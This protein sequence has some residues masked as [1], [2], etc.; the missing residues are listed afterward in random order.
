[1]TKE[2]SLSEYITLDR[3]AASQGKEKGFTKK[4]RIAIL[5]SFTL[6]GFK[7]VLNVK[8]RQSRIKAL[9]YT[10]DY[11]RYANDLLDRESRLYRFKPEITFLF[12]D[13]KSLFGEL[14]FNP[15]GA[16]EREREKASRENYQKLN[17][18]IDSFVKHGSGILVVNNLEIPV[19]SPVGILEPKQRFGY[20]D[21]VRDLNARISRFNRH[22]S[23]F[24][25]DYDSFASA[26]GKKGMVDNKLAY[27]ADMKIAPDKIP[28]LCEEYMRY[29]GPLLGL[30]KKC[31]V[32]DMD[33]TLWGGIVGEDGL[34]GID[35]GPER[36]GNAYMEFQKHLLALFE[37]GIILAAN[38]SN[39]E[40]DV[41]KVLREHPH[42]V[43]KEHHFA[44]F[45]VNWNNKAKNL[46]EIAK[47][48]NIG[49]DSMIFLEDDKRIRAFIRAALPQ[50]YCPDIPED[51]S[52]YTEFL[53]SIK[54]LDSLQLTG[55]DKKR[56]IGYI[57]ERKR[58]ESKAV[59]KSVSGYL[60]HLSITVRI[61][62]AD[63]FSVPRIA[64]LTTR[65]N[66]FN[67]SA[68]RYRENEI[69]RF[70]R[71]KRY[72]VYSVSIKDKYGDY[73]ITGALIVLKSEKEWSVDTFLLSCRILGRNIEEAILSDIIRR[74]VKAKVRT[75]SVF[76]KKTEKNRPVI[77]F[78]K[79]CGLLP[80][81]YDPKGAQI[82]LY[83]KGRMP[84][85]TKRIKNIRVISK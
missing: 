26:A 4:I 74:V 43:L 37:R 12:V 16:P 82:T 5:G 15:Y 54:N 75:L 49:L 55:E 85:L 61:E 59:F 18:F 73:G 69:E 56:S 63:K 34:Q 19:Y 35:L 64:Q 52:S 10:G 44:S 80:Q 2:L 13:T 58:K 53:R 9:F 67:F 50:V 33:N 24:V 48:I 20:F 25:F 71:D 45:K 27:L 84:D 77:N 65:T 81:K 66:Q 28:D 78:L 76:Y 23:V 57:A 7:E 83:E 72:G 51:P 8:C 68:K 22:N 62:P 31:I 17:I 32:L 38:S 3:N 40:D 41:L 60:K 36:P 6:S 46:V 30:S 70:S 79:D 39:N 14:F 11:N 29:I 21:M 47:D 42:M 1:M